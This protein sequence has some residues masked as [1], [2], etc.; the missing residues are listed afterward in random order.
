MLKNKWYYKEITINNITEPY[1]DNEDCGKDYM[2]FY[3]VNSVKNIDVFDCEEDTD[4]IGTYSRVDNLLTITANSTTRES[5][6][7]E[8]TN[9]SLKLQYFVDYNNDGVLEKHL[10]T[11]D[12]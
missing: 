3:N 11:F 5:E 1:P 2:Q 6:I 7:I 12:R 9:H 8:L 4:W 10:Y